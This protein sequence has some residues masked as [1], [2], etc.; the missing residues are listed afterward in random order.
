MPQCCLNDGQG[1]AITRQTRGVSMA[2]LVWRVAHLQPGDDMEISEDVVHTVIPQP[3][4]SVCRQKEG[5]T[6]IL[7]ADLQ[8]IAQGLDTFSRK[9]NGARAIPFPKTNENLPSVQM[10]VF[11]GE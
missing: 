9:K 3:P 2:K 6:A 11:G 7:R 1:N 4:S 10:D 5:M 8:K